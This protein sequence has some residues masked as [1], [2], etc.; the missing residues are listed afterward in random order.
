MA[1]DKLTILV[2]KSDGTFVRE[3][4]S[5]IQKKKQGNIATAE[6]LV[7]PKPALVA[8]PPIKEKAVTPSAPVAPI[9][10]P[11]PQ[12]K[13]IVFPKKTEILV[14]EKP[15]DF[16]SLLEDTDLPS[17]SGAVRTSPQR[18][19][20]VE[21]IINQ[22][23]FSVSAGFVDRLRNVVQLRIKDIRGMNETRDLVLRS[24]KDGGLGLTEVQANEL[25]DKCAIAMNLLPTNFSEPPTPTTTSPFNSFIHE[26]VKD[27]PTKKANEKSDFKISS[28]SKPQPIVRDIMSA[29]VEIGPVEEIKFFRLIDLRRL[30][31]NTDEAVNRLKQKFINL[32]EESVLL[33]LDAALAWRESPL[34][35]E[36]L[37]LIDEAFKKHLKIET[38]AFG[39]DKIT[40]EEIKALIKMEKELGL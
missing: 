19:S 35:K 18:I 7:L 24:I 25:E 38:V 21:K 27:N 11:K 33:F 40:P 13:P 22:L 9:E 1:D 32:K 10:P 37:D 28:V 6:D 3:P 16:R 23:S 17:N 12:I 30:S 39:K 34:Y 20:E 31:S 36:Y 5:E 26:G 2:K 29:A 15:S 14:K 8:P 4:L